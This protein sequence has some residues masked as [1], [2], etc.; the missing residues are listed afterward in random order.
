MTRNIVFIREEIFPRNNSRAKRKEQTK[1]W[2]TAMSY[3]VSH[4]K[5]SQVF[6]T[7]SLSLSLSL[8]LSSASID[9][10][11]GKKWHKD[12]NTVRLTPLSQFSNIE[13]RR[14]LSSSSKF[15]YRSFVEL[16]DTRIDRSSFKKKKKKKRDCLSNSSDFFFILSLYNFWRI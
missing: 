3:F 6:Q 11:V 12:S 9:N 14:Y 8:W 2:K 10:R 5:P 15:F 4:S 1:S 7:R 13:E 16:Q